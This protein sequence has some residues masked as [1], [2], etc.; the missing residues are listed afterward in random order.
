M[1]S[2]TLFGDARLRTRYMS[3]KSEIASGSHAVI[4]RLSKSE[5]ESRAYY[6]LMSN[7]RFSLDDLM[8]EI[9]TRSSQ[10]VSGRHVLAISDSTEFNLHSQLNNFSDA[11][12]CGYLSDNHS[13]GLHS[14]VTLALDADHLWALGLC[15]VQLWN[16]PKASK[17]KS[18]TQRGQLKA[19]EKESYKWTLGVDASEEVL[20]HADRVTYV[21]DREGDILDLYHHIQAKG[22]DFVIRIK[23]NR[24]LVQPDLLMSEAVAAQL[25]QDTYQLKIRGEK[26]R[27]VGDRRVKARTKRVAQMDLR[28]MPIQLK[29]TEKSYYLV[30]ACEQD[31]TVPKGEEPIHWR[32]LTS[33]KLETGADALLI[34]KY[35]AARWIIEQLFRI[36]KTQGFQIEDTQLGKISS[37]RKQICLC[38]DAA[39]RLLQLTLAKDNQE[40]MPLELVF[41]QEQIQLLKIL[42]QQLQGN[43]TKQQNPHRHDQLA[44]ATWV[45]ARLGGWKG[46]KS[47]RPPGPITILRGSRIFT[48]MFR[49]YDLLRQ[50]STQENLS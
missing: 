43:T 6:R 21:F 8:C 14:H 32:L 33:H 12:D 45:L 28:Y 31:Q 27:K 50:K 10:Q 35:Y 4:H 41:S 11:S 22:S 17:K 9:G 7:S 49:I 47:K 18:S 3:L 5:S 42:S 38:L 20:T 2:T 23:Q 40:Q 48:N 37:V 1:S 44:F 25:P 30:D 39:V 24:R 46:Y 16:R 34:L 15:D 19:Q 13:R 26:A 29:D 36:I